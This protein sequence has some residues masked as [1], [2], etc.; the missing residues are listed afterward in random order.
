MKA[1][2]GSSYRSSNSTRTVYSVLHNHGFFYA[3]RW[4]APSSIRKTS[5]ARDTKYTM[6]SL[7]QSFGLR[8]INCSRR[9]H[10][11]TKTH[12]GQGSL[13]LTDFSRLL[14]FQLDE[15]RIWHTRN[16]SKCCRLEPHL[17]HSTK[18]ISFNSVYRHYITT[19]ANN[20]Q[21]MTKVWLPQLFASNFSSSKGNFFKLKNLAIFSV[22]N[23]FF[24]RTQSI[25]LTA[26][27]TRENPTKGPPE[28]P[29]S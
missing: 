11:G 10:A 3:S 29:H 21:P 1:S 16:P 27:L 19:R 17:K 15:W 8:P 4:G 22:N 20:R 12:K 2:P 14:R 9:L 13:H 26:D 18:W 5:T 6:V 28:L 25:Q 23:S 7:Q 24:C